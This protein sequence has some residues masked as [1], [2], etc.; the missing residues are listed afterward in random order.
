MNAGDRVA[1][2]LSL[3][4]AVVFA[5]AAAL[6]RLL[7]AASWTMLS[8]SQH[9]Y[10]ASRKY[11]HSVSGASPI[12]PRLRL[13]PMQAAPGSSLTPMDRVGRSIH[14]SPGPG[15]APRATPS[16]VTH[17]GVPVPVT[18]PTS[19]GAHPVPDTPSRP[20][21]TTSASTRSERPGIALPQTWKRR[22]GFWSPGVEGAS[23]SGSGSATY[24]A[25]DKEREAL[26]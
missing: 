13:S 10:Q 15:A 26:A 17:D 14:R 12:P 6:S 20:R 1:M 24:E 7:I 4:R 22:K 21:P 3:E 5:A 2:T 9:G 18:H 19:A 8:P 11:T 16:F 25:P 23:R